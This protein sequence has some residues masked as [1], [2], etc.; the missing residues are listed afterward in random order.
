MAIQGLL[1][2]AASTVV[3]GAVGVAAYNGVRK[4][5]AKA[6]LREASVSALALALR[7]ARKAEGGA[8]SARLQTVPPG[9]ATTC[10][11]AWKWSRGSGGSGG[12]A[13][14]ESPRDGPGAF[15]AGHYPPMRSADRT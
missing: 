9:R 4:A 15:S 11:I 10:W 5:L 3:T 6:P 2:K 14:W 8:G 7:G 13:G 1:V 12:I